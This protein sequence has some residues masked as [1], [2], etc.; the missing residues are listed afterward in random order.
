LVERTER[1][2]G[3]CSTQFS[4]IARGARAPLQPLRR[5]QGRAIRQIYYADTA[6]LRCA[7]GGQHIVGMDALSLRTRVARHIGIAV[8]FLRMLSWRSGRCWR[9]I[10]Q[11]GLYAIK[12]GR[13]TGQRRTELHDRIDCDVQAVALGSCSRPTRTLLVK[14]SHCSG[15][16]DGGC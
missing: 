16:G 5:R 11:P 1:N 10:L 14:S 13:W 12:C 8:S 2:G 6:H 15:N 4:E 3:C 7:L 9:G